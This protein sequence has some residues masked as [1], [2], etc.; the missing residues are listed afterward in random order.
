MKKI[1]ALALSTILILSLA[2]FAQGQTDSIKSEMHFDLGITRDMNIN[3]WPIFKRYKTKESNEVQVIF[4]LFKYKRNYLTPAKHS[5]FFPVY[6][7]DS[8][9]AGKDF[10]FISLYYPSVVRTSK[11]YVR[12]SSSFKF[13]ELAPEINF[14]EFTK[15]S[16]GLF[17]QNNMLFM[18]WFKNDLALHK[19]HFIFFPVYWSFK[20]P[21]Y[22]TNT[23]FPFTSWGTYNQNKENYSAITPLYWHFKKIDGYRN[24]LFPLWLNRKRG[25]GENATYTNLF[26]PVYWSLRD[27][28]RDNKVLF[29]II[30]KFKNA[31][32]SSF[33]L[34]PI[35]SWGKSYNYSKDFL[36][37]TPAFWHFTR[38]DATNNIL[39]PLWWNRK[40]GS[41]NEAVSSTLVIPVYWSHRNSIK[42]NKILFPFIWSIKN[43]IYNSFTFAPLL[44]T[45]HS[46]DSSQNHLM[47]TPLIWH[48]K[49]GETSR[50]VVFPIWWYK[51]IGQGDFAYRSNI[52]APFYI[53]FGDNVQ[54]TQ[55]IF[56]LIWNLKNEDYSSFTFAPLFSSGRSTNDAIGH[57]MITP[58]FWNFRNS[59]SNTN[60]LFPI[61]WYSLKGSGNN[62]IYS[63][64][65]FPIYF[66]FKDNSKDNTVIFPVHWSLRNHRYNSYTFFPLYSKGSSINGAKTHLMI[67]PLYWQFN[68]GEKRR[69]ILFPLWLNRESGSGDNWDNFKVVFPFYWAYNDKVKDNKVLFPIIWSLKDTHYNKLIVAPFFSNGHSPDNKYGYLM[70]TPLYW[71]F[72]IDEGYRNILFPLWWNK[73]RGTGENI[74]YSNLIIPIYWAHKDKQKENKVIF[75]II[76][77]LKNQHYN[78]FTAVPFFSKG[79]SSDSSKTHLTIT[80]L[81]WQFRNGVDY[82]IVLFPF[83][84]NTKTGIGQDEVYNK[85]AFPFYW[86]HKGQRENN[87]ILF[88]IYWNLNNEKYSSITIVPFFSTGHS[89][90]NTRCHLMVT[91]LFWHHKD[92]FKTSNVFFPIWWNSN[93]G[94]ID[95]P[96]I[97]NLVLPLYWSVKD[98]E[99]ENTVLFP[100]L[101]NFKNSSYSSTTLFPL[102]SFGSTPD[103]TWRHFVVMP[104]LWNIIKGDDMDRF[105]IPIWWSHKRGSGEDAISSTIILPVF[106]THQDS[107]KDNAFVFPLVWSLKNANYR[108]FTFAPLFSV[109]HS[110]EKRRDH[111]VVTPL[112]WHFK[113]A[114]S[115]HNILIPIYWNSK[116]GIGEQVRYTNVILP[117]YLSVKDAKRNNRILFPI[118]WNLKNSKY[119]STTLFPIFSIGHSPDSSKRHLAITPL[120]WRIQ[121][122]EYKRQTI[123]PF[124]SRYTDIEGKS[125]YSSLVFVVRSHKEKARKTISLIWP[126]CEYT[127]NV[128]YRYFRF[129]P[130]IW[131]KKALTSSYFSIQPFYLQSRDSISKNYYILWQFYT[132]KNYFNEKVSRNILW[133]AVT[134]DH[135]YNNDYEFRI[136]YLLYANVMK[137]GNT[138]RTLFPLYQYTHQQ[139]GNKSVA[140]LF[141]F[142][143]SLRRKIPETKEYYQEQR[144]FWF[145]R[146]RSNY[147]DLKGK[148]I[149]E[150]LIKQ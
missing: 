149:K 34:A 66:R 105:L 27:K 148:G 98:K 97:T 124:Y 127:K 120:Y 95:N 103:R 75:P 58:L 113:N 37:V 29:P 62:Q 7:S 11:D 108:S 67:T 18:L 109:G 117:L 63:N 89:P 110:T 79:I 51:R 146:L 48:F 138:E 135:Y 69:T 85:V 71:H 19:S 12:N 106:W 30:W 4:P 1:A 119:R 5:H 139:N 133:K 88:P 91:P 44:S 43:S 22:S 144:I 38:G 60:L 122:P 84:W 78:S 125:K 17:V 54:K 111:V 16:N 80:P 36:V 132:H 53:C 15:S 59:D 24:V 118:V 94:T 2:P 99:T 31:S 77:N 142:Y 96:R 8:S 116:R 47:V 107:F 73:K 42:N 134:W 23:I 129:A 33:T 115:E 81:F 87:T 20:N 57:L 70:V 35:L 128:N 102:I 140:L 141:Y 68:S 6:L 123:F 131:Y 10:R 121:R 40:K 150:S 76:W 100:V 46:T 41:G 145:I 136:L 45:G 14:V 92:G 137:Q 49:K 3:L 9:A 61:W 52:I 83:W 114:Y 104:L 13:I 74:V 86:Y 112:F 147:K 50:N 101:W 21:Q 32:R 126:I 143:S 25:L 130:I 28:D 64:I 72:R 39:F 65:L 26:V 93:L 90:D 55:I 82:R 56:P